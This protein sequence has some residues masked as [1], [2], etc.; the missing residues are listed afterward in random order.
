M[1]NIP[2]TSSLD[3]R[4]SSRDDDS[5]ASAGFTLSNRR[6]PSSVKLSLRVVRWNRRTPSDFSSWITD[7]L[8]ACGEMPWSMAARR[9]LPSVAVRTKTVMARIS[10]MEQ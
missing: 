10:F 2:F 4:A 9:K 3:R 5:M 7:W 8:A 6:W 1:R